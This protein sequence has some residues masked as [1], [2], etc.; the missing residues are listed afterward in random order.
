MTLVF[1]AIFLLILFSLH[2][3]EPEF[4]PNWRMVSEYALGSYGWMMSLAFFCWGASIFSLLAAL[5]PHLQSRAGAIG[6]YWMLIVGIA[7]IGAGIFATNPIVEPASSIAHTI[8]AICGAIMILTFP[9][10]ASII[11]FALSR[12]AEWAGEKPLLLG[13]SLLLWLSLVAFFGSIIVSRMINPDAG[14][15]GPDV[16]L[17][18]PN[19]I[20]VLVYHSWLIVIALRARTKRYS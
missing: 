6:R 9:I 1:S 12:K 20:N 11:A 4:D 13:I 10:A 17:G 7:P 15:V 2:F 19:R 5:W 18:W 3:L 16:Y 14:R 8:H